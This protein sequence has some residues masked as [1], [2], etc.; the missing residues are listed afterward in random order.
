VGGSRKRMVTNVNAVH[1]QIATLLGPPMLKFY[2]F[3]EDP[4]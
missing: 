1:V 3:A 4:L 2:V